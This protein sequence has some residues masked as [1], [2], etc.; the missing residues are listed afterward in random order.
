[1]YEVGDALPVRMILDSEVSKRHRDPTQLHHAMRCIFL[2]MFYAKVKEVH[3]AIPL[4]IERLTPTG[5]LSHMV[6]RPN[7]GLREVGCLAL[8]LIIL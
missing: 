5:A 1:M 8:L 3:G 6:T 4:P 7:P 2:Y